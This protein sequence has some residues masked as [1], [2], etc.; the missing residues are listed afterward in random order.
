MQNERISFDQEETRLNAN[1]DE[2]AAL[3]ERILSGQQAGTASSSYHFIC[4][5][6]FTTAKG[7]HLGLLKVISACYEAV[8]VKPPRDRAATI[9]GQ[10][11]VGVSGKQQ[12]LH[13]SKGTSLKTGW[14][15]SMQPLRLGTEVCYSQQRLLGSHAQ[16]VQAC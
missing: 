4:E 7:M 9:V 8:Q 1:G 3:Q 12:H 15:F 2:Q 13:H 14:G 5:C 6:F 10:H 16:A 11:I